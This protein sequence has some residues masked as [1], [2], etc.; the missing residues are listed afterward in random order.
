MLLLNNADVYA[1]AATGRADILAAGGR[2]LRIEPSIELPPAYVEEVDASG[3][4]AVPGFI[5]GHVHMID[6]K[7]VV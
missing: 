2:I 5:D 6:R 3:L 7:S 1:P 4:I